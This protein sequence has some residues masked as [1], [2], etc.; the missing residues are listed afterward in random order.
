MKPIT[1]LIGASFAAVAASVCCILPVVLGAGAAGTLGVSAALTPYRPYF[2]GLTLLLLGAA[3]YFT[4]R[5]SKTPC[6]VDGQCATEKTTRVKRFSK[7]VLWGV[8][9]LTVGAMLFPTL[10]LY[11]AESQA[12][13]ASPAQMGAAP[14]ATIKTARFTVNKMTCADC[15]FQ[16]V[17][18]L[19]KTS[20]VREAKVNFETKE[21]TVHYDAARVNAAKLRAVI[22]SL[23]YS[24]A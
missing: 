15:S 13:S 5:P 23:G 16:I 12:A 9:A 19:K 17:D 11:R 18:A 14:A 20:G 22:E 10:A 6:D 7:A 24:A 4:Y 1:T 21:A 3:F 2:I 8:T